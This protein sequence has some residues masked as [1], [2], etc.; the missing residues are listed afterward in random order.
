MPSP[1]AASDVIAMSALRALAAHGLR[2]P[3]GVG[4][5]GYD[6]F[7]GTPARVLQLRLEGAKARLA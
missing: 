5:V 2:V 1:V 4:V 3:Q 6:D 7:G